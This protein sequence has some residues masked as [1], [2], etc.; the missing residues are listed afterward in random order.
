M[1]SANWKE[2]VLIVL[3]I[4]FLTLEQLLPHRPWTWLKHRKHESISVLQLLF[5]SR[6][7][8]GIFWSD[9]L[10][11]EEQTCLGWS[12]LTKTTQETEK[13]EKKLFDVTHGIKLSKHSAS[14]IVCFSQG[15]IWGRRWMTFFLSEFF[16]FVFFWKLNLTLKKS[17]WFFHSN[18]RHKDVPF[19]NSFFFITLN[20]CK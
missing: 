11:Q 10:Q 15:C 1:H 17:T 20:Q 16:F 9:T 3:I 13:K 6:V 2:T 14:V 19:R 4:V 5:F 12:Y 7:F 18:R 8:K